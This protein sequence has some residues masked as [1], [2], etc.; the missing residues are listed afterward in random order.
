MVMGEN[1][2]RQIVEVSVTGVAAIALSV[3]LTL[4]DSAFSHIVR[5]TPGAFDSIGPAKS[6]DGFIALC[7]V[8]KVVDSEHL[9]S[10]LGSD[11]LSKILRLGSDTFSS[12]KQL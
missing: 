8:D 3:T 5:F 12:Q 6:A 10:M 1:G 9:G 7:V 4:M 11:S 2:V